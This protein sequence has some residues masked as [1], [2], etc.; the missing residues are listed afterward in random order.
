LNG[1]HRQ[2]TWVKGCLRDGD[3][4]LLGWVGGSQ[5]DCK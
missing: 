3:G 5:S 1:E 2:G 4:K